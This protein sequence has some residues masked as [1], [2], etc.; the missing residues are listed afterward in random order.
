MDITKDK[1]LEMYHTMQKIRHFE[2]KARDLAV[3][4][5]IP[6]FV[7]V[8]IGEK[9]SATGVCAALR[10]TDRITSTHRGHGHLIAKGGRLDRMMAEIFGKRTGYC[11]GKG[12]SMHIVDYSL[13]ILGANGIVGGGLP[14]A[15]GSALGAAFA[16]QGDGTAGFF[17]GG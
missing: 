13:G 6:G 16:G 12:G 14:I 1:L 4:S 5:E 17:G 7:H 8:S 15:A 11:K 10:K 3:A 9:A 2:S